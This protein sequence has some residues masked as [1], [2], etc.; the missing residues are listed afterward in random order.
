MMPRRVPVLPDVVL[1]TWSLSN[2]VR[3]V[4]PTNIKSARLLSFMKIGLYNNRFQ[5]KIM[6]SK[7][8]S[9]SFMRI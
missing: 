1:L 4:S 2:A 8:S 9:V 7:M 3:K 6:N 5:V